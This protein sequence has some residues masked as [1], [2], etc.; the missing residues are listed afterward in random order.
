MLRRSV[1]SA[2]SW[3]ALVVII[4]VWVPLVTITWLVTAPFDK[5]RYAAGYL[6]LLGPGSWN[7]TSFILSTIANLSDQ[8]L[9]TRLDV[10]SQLRTWISVDAAV[11]YY[12]GDQGEFHYGLTIP[13]IPGVFEEEVV[14]PAQQWAFSAGAQVKF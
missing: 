7:D 8:S 4:I 10:R 9:V 11:S 12:A 3:F 5:G 6:F 13:A 1:L 14:I 2:F